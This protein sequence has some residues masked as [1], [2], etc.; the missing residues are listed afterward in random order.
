MGRKKANEDGRS[1]SG[2][3]PD[4]NISAYWR[5]FYST[6]PDLLE[7]RSNEEAIAH[8]RAE[9]GNAEVPPSVI[10][11]LTNVKSMVRKESGIKPK[12]KR[13]RPKKK[14]A[15][16]VA[17]APVARVVKVPTKVLEALEDQIDKCLT[18]IHNQDALGKIVQVLKQ[19]RRLTI[20]EIGE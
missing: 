6:R 8:W 10:N 19:A 3:A 15:T 18:L 5:D 20:L 16:A 11:G 7:V 2:D 9:H 14:K 1:K 12:K 13:G 4:D 17:A